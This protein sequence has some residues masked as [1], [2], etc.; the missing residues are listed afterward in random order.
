MLSW[1]SSFSLDI[2]NVCRFVLQ[3]TAAIMTGAQTIGLLTEFCPLVNGMR[4]AEF[5]F[6]LAIDM[7][8]DTSA[9]VLGVVSV[10]SSFIRSKLFS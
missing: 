8:P 4:A 10:L 7:L 3:T 1:T 2:C 9:N 5:A 6:L